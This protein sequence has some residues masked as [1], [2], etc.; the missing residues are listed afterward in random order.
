MEESY[1]YFCTLQQVCQICGLPSKGS[2]TTNPNWPRCKLA[3]H[4]T[5][6][7]IYLSF[8]STS[9]TTKAQANRPIG[10]F[11]IDLPTTQMYSN[12]PYLEHSI[13]S[14]CVHCTCKC[15]TDITQIVNGHRQKVTH[16]T[17]IAPCTP[18]AR[19]SDCHCKE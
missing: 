18:T 1:L 14:P 2:S 8:H 5:Q 9:F 19:V 6:L 11:Y 15:C 3:K 12:K 10:S 17:L 16:C 4:A 7:H 13:Q